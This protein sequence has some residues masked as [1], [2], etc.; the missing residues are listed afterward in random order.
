M[1]GRTPGSIAKREECR[2]IGESGVSYNLFEKTS[3]LSQTIKTNYK[4]PSMFSKNLSTS[5][6]VQADS[7]CGPCVF[8]AEKNP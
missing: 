5:L 2:V 6:F 1:D 3:Q 8:F 7:L 4:F